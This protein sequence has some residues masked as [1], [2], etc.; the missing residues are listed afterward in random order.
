MM[1]SWFRKAGA[2]VVSEARHGD[3]PALAAIHAQ[4]FER[5]WDTGE[6]ERLLT[7]PNVACHV[8][9][10]GGSGSP[11]GF[12]MSRQVD[13]EAEVLTIAVASAA[14]GR[15]IAK[16]MLGVHLGRLAGRGVRE[17]FLEVAADNGAALRLY[18][19]FGFVE[20]GRRAGYYARR[21]GP[22][23]TALI[24]RLPLG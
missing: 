4:G 17:I 3:G 19:H 15:G 16:A 20:V 9:R 23:A 18:E 5:G 1:L 11:V 13:R 12:A 7:E 22:A 21:G 14:R 10:P 8:A 6:F 2:P 24:M